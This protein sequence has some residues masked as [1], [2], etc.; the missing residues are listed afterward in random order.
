M[1]LKIDIGQYYPADT[2]I[3]RMDPRA[4]FCCA[5]A[6]LISDFLVATPL[7]LLVSALAA[8]I[9][10][11]LSR[12][13]LSKI[14]ASVRPIVILLAVLSLF[15]LF[16]VRTGTPLLTLGALRIT[17]DSLWAAVL[18]TAR[19]L[20]ALV[21]GALL[22]TTTTPTALADA[23][24]KL[25]SPLTR[26]GLPGHEIA[27]V[28]SLM[29]RFIPILAD[30]ASAIIDAQ[31]ARGGALAEG[32]MRQRF[33]AIIPVLVALFASALRHANGLSRALDAR[34]YEGGAGRTHY[35]ELRIRK[36][37]V[38]ALLLCALYVCCLLGPLS[39]LA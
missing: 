31:A 23:F 8:A 29:L 11:A 38:V 20:V 10:V 5:L 28:F 12:V 4:K 39:T 2:P 37:D 22:L 1:A 33:H 32:S 17:D 36:P 34:C 30:E 35:H 9:I 14:L 24:D 27:M 16:F 6:I 19:F 3:H 13:P 21:E 26:I 25:L 15:N 7:Q 18:Y